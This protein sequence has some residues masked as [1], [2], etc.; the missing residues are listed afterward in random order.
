MS[1]PLLWGKGEN[2]SAGMPLRVRQKLGP[3]YIP[4]YSEI[5][6]A[7]DLATSQIITTSTK[8]K[9]YKRDF[10]TGPQTLPVEFCYVRVQGPTGENSSSA[11]EDT[12]QYTKMGYK[13]VIVTSQED[14]AE[15]FQA[16]PGIGFPP[17][18]HIGADGMIRHRDAALFYV[19]R[20]TAD[21]LAQDRLEENK[22]FL[23]HNQPGPKV[24]P[25]PY[26]F[27]ADAD[28]D[29]ISGD[30]V[31]EETWTERHGSTL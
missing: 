7:N 5:V 29:A 2:E 25:R 24:E 4:G 23:G 30:F 19:D 11:N 22:R 28:S 18:A 6:M 26:D 10:G 31:D 12:F 9:Y 14:F 3:D 13:A 1:K 16:I 20:K 21:R 27:G 8:E 17:A 15:Q